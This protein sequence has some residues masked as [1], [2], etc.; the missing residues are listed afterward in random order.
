MGGKTQTQTTNSNQSY[1]PAGL[2]Q[3]NDIWNKVQGAASTPYTP[4]TGQLTAGLDPTQQAGINTINNAQGTAQPYYDQATQY[5][6]QAAAPISAAQI[7]NYQSPYTQQVVDATQ[8]QFNNAN[9]Q[10][11]QQVR[12]NAALQGAL[13]GSREAVAEAETA[14]QQSLA[15][16]PTIAGLYNNSYTQA[17]GAAQQDRSA[18]AQAAYSLG[19]LG[20]AVQNTALQGGAAQLGAGAVAQGTDQNA[21]TAQY[22]QYLQQQAF[23]YQQA[24]FLASYGLPTATG[25]GGTQTGNSETTQQGPSGLAQALGLGI[26]GIGALGQAG[27]AAGIAGLAALKRGGRVNGKTIPETKE[28]LGEQQKQLVAGNRDV[29]MFPHGTR[30]LPL[31]PGMKRTAGK[32]GVFHYNPRRMTA[33]RINDASN[34]GRENELLGL[35]PLSK[36][37]VMERS[38]SAATPLSIVERTPHG[39]EVRAAAATSDTVHEQLAHM[40]MHKALGNT[41]SV[42]RPEHTIARRKRGYA[43]GGSVMGA[44]NFILVPSFIPQAGGAPQS[45]APQMAPMQTAK[46]TQQPQS[47][48]GGITPASIASAGKAFGGLGNYLKLGD[49]GLGNWNDPSWDGGTPLS[50]GADIGG[51]GGGIGMAARGGRINRGFSDGG[52]V[53]TVHSIRR[54]L[55]GAV[56]PSPFVQGYDIGGNVDVPDF[57]SRWADVDASN[58]DFNRP[59]DVA[60][61]YPVINADTLGLGK[62]VDWSPAQ[63]N[64]PAMV[65]AGA[66]PQAIQ[67]ADLPPQITN[68]DG[69]SPYSPSMAMSFAGGAPPVSPDAPADD[70]STTD[71][72]AQSQQPEKKST[73][74][75]GLS[76]NA[77]MALIAAGLGMAASRSPFALSAIGEGGLQGVNTY[78]QLT[79]QDQDQT[80]KKQEIDLR[81]K[82]LAQTASQFATT[83]GET[84]RYHDILDQQRKDALAERQT[85]AGYIR[86]PDGTMTP[87]QGGPAD[88]TQ[89]AAVAKAKQT[90]SLLPDDTADFLAE[91]VINGDTK[92]LIGLGRGAQGAENISRVQT[93]VAKKAADRGMDAQDILQKSAEASGLNAQQRTFG[94]QTAKMAINSTEAQGAIQLGKEASAN[95]PRGNW[96]PINKVIQAYQ[97]GTSDPALA[98]FGAA[99]LAIVNTYAR[100]INPTGVPHAADKEHAMQLLSTATGPDAYNAV[101]DQLNQE[102]QIAHSAA[103]KAKQ[104]MEDI[105]KGRPNAATAATAPAASIPQRVRQNGHTYERQPDGSMKAID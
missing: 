60:S 67:S 103:P 72:S 4:Y 54:A 44:D 71:L 101:L 93:L 22:Q 23:P 21:L 16:N 85:R 65:A 18:Q 73:G 81:A 74:L 20:S 41:L 12:G 35:G 62:A 37:D 66:S 33:A 42:E 48:L 53:D 78:N 14:K 97:S 63:Q 1:T 70:G 34:K 17:L 8:S 10:Q 89:I 57:S 98:K 104:E 3:L 36:S 26:A 68:P 76:S 27:G 87:I 49:D 30:E 83:T 40:R 39:V 5:A 99:N 38:S 55:G 91:R 28:T 88:P 25:M 19:S 100:A 50:G 102:I 59:A 2:S 29:Q 51:A 56:S 13:G 7:Q 105:R 80:N 92:A 43:S 11:F 84:K 9:A 94:T 90:G 96:V 45:H 24:Q 31:P 46:I 95:V 15:Q 32:N 52:F 58:D 47:S 64:A 77:N 75:F 82:Q 79:K 86:N 6:N 61:P 69:Q